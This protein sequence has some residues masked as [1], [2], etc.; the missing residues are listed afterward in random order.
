MTNEGMPP[1]PEPDSKGW[2][3]THEQMRAYGR[4]IAEECAKIADD[5]CDTDKHG[6][7]PITGPGDAIRSRFGV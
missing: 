1:L 5:A 2:I 4:L 3:Y 6:T 7:S